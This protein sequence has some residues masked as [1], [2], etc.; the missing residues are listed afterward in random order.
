MQWNPD[1]VY[2]V[3]Q[4]MMKPFDTYYL[5]KLY[6]G[7]DFAN[8]LE[9]RERLFTSSMCGIFALM[10]KKVIPESQYYIIEGNHPRNPNEVVK[11]I[12]VKIEDYF[13]DATGI[14]RKEFIAL[15]PT[16]LQGETELF[17]ILPLDY[18]DGSMTAFYEEMM[19]LCVASGRKYAI[20]R[21]WLTP[22]EDKKKTLF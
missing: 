2:L 14:V 10:L 15:G 1:R 16:K 21:G 20:K 22:V 12:I 19:A 4:E 11:H 9:E 7:G 5:T 13:Y 8:L 6:Y 3:I 18:Q 17:P